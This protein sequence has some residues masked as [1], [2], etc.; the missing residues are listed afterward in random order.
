MTKSHVHL[1][2]KCGA[3]K[4]LPLYKRLYYMYSLTNSTR[5]QVWNTDKTNRHPKVDKE[6]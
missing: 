6:F 4:L 3:Q 2:G 5:L 1:I